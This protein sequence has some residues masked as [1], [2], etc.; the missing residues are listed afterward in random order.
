MGKKFRRGKTQYFIYALLKRDSLGIATLCR[1]ETK[2]PTTFDGCTPNIYL[3][4]NVAMWW[5]RLPSQDYFLPREKVNI[6]H[7][8][9]M[10]NIALKGK[11]VVVPLTR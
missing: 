10:P 9:N 11:S 6:M 8:L 3:P 1:L 5:P 2:A 7:K 4:V